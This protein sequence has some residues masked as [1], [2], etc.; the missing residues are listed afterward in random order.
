MQI[1]LHY[2]PQLSGL[3]LAP[4]AIGVLAAKPLSQKLLRRGGYKNFLITN[5][6]GL[7]LWICLFSSITENSSSYYIALLTLVYGFL[8]ALQYTAMNSLAYAKVG[9]EI[10][11]A[12]TSIISTAQQLA[13]SFGV[14]LAAILVRSFAH[15]HLLSLK[16]FHH[17]FYAMG[18][19]TL[20]CIF[21]FIGLEKNDGRELIEKTAIH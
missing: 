9:Q 7:G 16:D 21:I 15:H 11:S 13:L 17:T 5:T 4:T 2:S 1:N 6:L 19:L 12:A 18:I 10:L 20:L 14:A 8:I 3:L